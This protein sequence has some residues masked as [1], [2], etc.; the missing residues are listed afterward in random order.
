MGHRRIDRKEMYEFIWE[1]TDENNCFVYSQG[2]YA[3]ILGIRFQWLSVIFN[4]FVQLGL[5]EKD[6][7]KYSPVYPPERV[8]WDKFYERLDQ[9]QLYNRENNR[10]K[11]GI[12]RKENVK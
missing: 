10:T 9:Y 6:K 4:E 7:Y 3:D 8:P 2:E 5:L 12:P 11:R 1:N